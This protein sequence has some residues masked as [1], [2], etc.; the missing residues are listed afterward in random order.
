MIQRRHAPRVT[1]TVPM[2]LVS[3]EELPFNAAIRFKPV[4]RSDTS[5]TESIDK[6]LTLHRVKGF[7]RRDMMLATML[8]GLEL[9]TNLVIKDEPIT[10]RPCGS[11]AADD[12][13][14]IICGDFLGEFTPCDTCT[15]AKLC[16]DCLD[17]TITIGPGTCP[18]CRRPLK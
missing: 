17:G 8:P 6:L 12:D 9:S 4:A 5:D 11:E 3:Y 15:G 13:D 14:C 2:S 18:H 7:V 1:F 16:E 10:R